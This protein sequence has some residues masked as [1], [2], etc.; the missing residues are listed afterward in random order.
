MHEKREK[1]WREQLEKFKSD[2]EIFKNELIEL[3]VNLL[4]DLTK[5]KDNFF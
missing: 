5:S 3:E 1:G 2:I 4:E